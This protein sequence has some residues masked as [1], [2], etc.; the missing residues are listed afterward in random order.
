M[1]LTLISEAIVGLEKMF[2]QVSEGEGVVE[3]CVI[4]SRPN[5]NLI[6]PISFPFDVSLSTEDGS[7]GIRHCSAVCLHDYN[8]TFSTVAPID[9]LGLSTI[10]MFV[11][12]GTQQCVNVVIVDDDVLENVE[13]FDVTLERTPGLDSRITLDPVDTVV[14]ITDDD[15]E[16]VVA[17]H[18]SN[19]ISS[20]DNSI[21]KW[22]W[23]VW[24]R[25]FTTSQRMRMW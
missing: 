17:I 24:R 5:R 20:A 2:H 22:L 12:C 21:L 1:K 19:D 9:Y 10:L 11:T 8:T 18:F 23:W 6:C 3:V 13:S 14:E 4:V 16:Y 25:H 15:G 7:A